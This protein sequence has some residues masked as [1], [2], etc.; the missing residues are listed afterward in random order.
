MFTNNILSICRKW[1]ILG[2]LCLCLFEFG[3][4]NRT[5]ESSA[6]RPC[7][8]YCETNLG[9]CNTACEPSCDENS[10]DAVCSSCL[11]AC[12]Q[13]YFQCLSY[14]IFCDGEVAQPG[15]CDVNFTTHCPVDVNGAPD[16][17]DPN[18]NH[19]G[20]STTCTALVGGYQCINC[21]NHEFCTQTGGLPNCP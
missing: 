10:T 19:M 7:M 17:N 9:E 15:R 21:P 18:N 4:T 3:Y 16:C 8:Q 2:I 1:A 20:Y 6:A 11:Q 12:S 5:V 14:A 13:Q